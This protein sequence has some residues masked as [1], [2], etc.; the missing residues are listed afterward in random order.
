MVRITKFDFI[1]EININ[2]TSFWDSIKLLLLRPRR[3][4]GREV[5]RRRNSHSSST[6]AA[7]GGRICR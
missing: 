3:Y 7:A 2:V 4:C 5:L 6:A 1:V